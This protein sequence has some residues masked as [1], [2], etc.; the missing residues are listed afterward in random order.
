MCAYVYG[1][2]CMCVG[3]CVCICVCVYVCGCVYCRS[4]GLSKVKQIK[5]IY[6]L[7]HT[8]KMNV[9]PNGVSV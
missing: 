6:M 1:C 9:F 5:Y 2:V 3:V 4:V 8:S 7:T